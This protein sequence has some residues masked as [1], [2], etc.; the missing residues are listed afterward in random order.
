MVSPPAPAGAHEIQDDKRPAPRRAHRRN[1]IKNNY[2]LVSGI[3]FQLAP[4]ADYAEEV[5]KPFKKQNVS[6]AQ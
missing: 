4:K 6:S 5:K 3:A 2:R 1:I